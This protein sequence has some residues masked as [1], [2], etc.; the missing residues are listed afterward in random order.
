M[1]IS[2]Y[3]IA[4]DERKFCGRWMESMKEAD[5]VAVLDTGSTDGTAETLRSLGA[6]VEVREIR[7]WRFDAARNESMRL[8]SPDA[9]LLVCTD[10]DEVLLPGWRARLE[11]A[12]K[13]AVAQG[14]HPTTA[15]YEYVWSFNPDGSDDIKFLYEK[16]HVPGVAKWEHP[17]HEVLGYAGGRKEMVRVEGMRLEHRADPEKS[18]AQYLPLLE[19]S[20]AE[21]PDDDR[22]MHYLGREYMFY[23]RWRDCIR[24]LK[25]HLA[26]P[27]AT[28]R[29]ERAASM[30]YIA[31]AHKAMGEMSEAE[32]WLL[33]AVMEA[34]DQRE[35][36]L[37]LAELALEAKDWQ[38]L[39]R[40]AE[41][42]LAVKDRV[43]TYLTSSEAWGARPYDLYSLGLWYSGRRE[44]AVAANAMAMSLAPEDG[45]LRDNDAVMRR[46]MAGEA[47]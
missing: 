45:R 24:T 18:R 30:R 8:V 4:K 36:S 31:R 27:A 16:V 7:P 43:M 35:P 41:T 40:A 21:C 13:E 37:E 28:W 22:N 19:M 20:V 15:Q 39:V 2:V 29:A 44:E 6:K 5:E 38:L 23:G 34:P 26:M 10:L 1:K 12:W 46:L 42:C 3:A 33:R 25:R 14:W 32:R 9:D 11:A 17:V 47:G